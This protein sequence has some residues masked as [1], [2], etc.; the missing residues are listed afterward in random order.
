MVGQYRSILITTCA[1]E[2]LMAKQRV[3]PA[4]VAFLELEDGVPP[5]MKAEAR[6][7]C[8]TA[9]KEWDYGGK[10]RWVRINHVDSLE[11]MRDLMALPEGRPETLIPGKLRSP[12]EIVVA[13]YILTRREEEL[14]LPIG[15]IKLCPMIESGPAVLYLKDVI[16]ASKRVSGVLLGSEDLSADV[17]IVRTP[18]GREIDWVRGHMVITAHTLGV[19][20]FDVASVILRDMDALYQETRRSYHLGFDGKACI[21]PTQIEPIHRGFMPT[22]DEI[23]WAR[24]LLKADKEAKE[25]GIAVFALDGRMVDGPFVMHAEQVLRRAGQ[26]V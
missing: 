15:G 5:D 12:N 4:D 7:R 26:E 19:K 20:C 21:S 24:R 2:K 9:L 13:D 17:G 11:G 18:E 23:A 8:V 1:N 6:A 3:A 14:G 16:Q 10:E 25:K 22:D